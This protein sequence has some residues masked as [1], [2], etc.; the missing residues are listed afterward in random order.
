MAGLEMIMSAA[1]NGGH[2]NHT[3]YDLDARIKACIQHHGFTEHDI[4]R[5]RQRNQFERLR[6]SMTKITTGFEALANAAGKAAEQWRIMTESIRKAKC[7]D[8][9]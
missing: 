2:H 1:K 4:K 6:R 9:L 8:L 7:N 3:V 5:A